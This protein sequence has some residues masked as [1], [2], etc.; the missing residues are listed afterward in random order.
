MAVKHGCGREIHWSS[1]ILTDLSTVLTVC[2]T[3]LTS[4]SIQRKTHSRTNTNTQ[5]RINSAR[6]Q[7]REANPLLDRWDACFLEE[8]RCTIYKRRSMVHKTWKC[9]V[10]QSCHIAHNNDSY[11]SHIILISGLSKR[12]CFP[13]CVKVSVLNS[14]TLSFLLCTLKYLTAVFNGK[15]NATSRISTRPNFQKSLINRLR[16][17]NKR[18]NSFAL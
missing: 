15:L 9:M 5:R 1:V 18:L 4:L 16:I 7:Q 14:Q 6:E 17:S 8:W 2:A 12:V 10:L 3:L 13:F 11:C